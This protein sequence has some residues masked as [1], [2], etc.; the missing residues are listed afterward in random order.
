[1]RRNE[2]PV[3]IPG[4][5]A[6]TVLVY[7]AVLSGN[8]SM[9]QTQGLAVADT[10]NHRILIYHFPFRTN[11]SASAVLGQG[12]FGG[13]RTNRG[14]NAAANTLSAPHGLSKDRAGSL[15]VADSWNC[16]VLQF[17]PPLISGLNA[18]HVF[19]QTG[20]T[21]VHCLLHAQATASGLD[22]PISVAVDGDGDLWVSDNWNSRVLEYAKPFHSGMS[23]AGRGDRAVLVLRP[24]R[25]VL[26]APGE[27]HGGGRSAA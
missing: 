26:P 20:F 19:G 23:A 16:R 14:A 22:L 15:Y 5:I 13:Q 24:Q 12:D 4:R 9:A 10:Q 11:E 8:R 7:C 27:W 25:M 1:M 6:L 21:A 18:T 17:Q 3:G 2:K